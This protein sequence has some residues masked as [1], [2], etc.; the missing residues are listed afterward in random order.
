[1]QAK[2]TAL[3]A[4]VAARTKAYEQARAS[5][6]AVKQALTE[7]D[8]ELK[9]LEKAMSKLRNQIQSSEVKERKLGHK[10]ARFEKE[11]QEAR[12]RT[13]GLLKRHPWIASEKQYFGKPHTDYDFNARDPSQAKARM[14]KLVSARDKLAKKINKKVMGMIEKA[15]DEYT[16]LMNKR[17]IVEGDRATIERVIEELESKKNQA[18]QQTWTK[19]NK[20]FG[21]IFSTLLA[22]S[23]AK[24]DPPENKTALDGLE[25]KVAFGQ[26]WKQS[27]SELSGGQRSLLALSL[28]LALLRFKP[29]PMYILGRSG[30]GPGPEPHSK[31]WTNPQTTFFSIPVHCSVPQRRY[32]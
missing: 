19:V 25:M 8:A 24:L 22:G 2:C 15:E 21:A 32:V 27:L 28:I 12:R 30:R 17:R 7:C 9:T 14:A 6:D 3:E 20:D 16:A 13:E 29:A 4:D 11:Q 26:T 18:L 10:L 31:H 5:L 23:N 1:M